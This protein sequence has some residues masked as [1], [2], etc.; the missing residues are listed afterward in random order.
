MTSLQD[1]LKG[2]TEIIQLL[3][4]TL[5]GADANVCPTSVI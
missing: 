1:V 2:S 4:Y 5:P 3:G